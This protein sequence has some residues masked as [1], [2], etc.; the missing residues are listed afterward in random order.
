M[1]IITL[2]SV[3]ESFYKNKI[4][5]HFDRKVLLRSAKSYRYENDDNLPKNLSGQILLQEIQ[6]LEICQENTAA[7]FAHINNLFIV[8]LKI[9]LAVKFQIN[10]N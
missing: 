9:F 4:F 3:F 6:S 8:F 2:Y 7:V 5:R 1:N 10:R